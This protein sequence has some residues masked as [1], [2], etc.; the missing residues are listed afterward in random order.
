[1]RILSIFLFILIFASC[2]SEK[3]GSNKENKLKMG[4]GCSMDST[5]FKKT[6]IFASLA[7]DRN[8]TPSAVSLLKYA[9]TRKSQGQQS[10]CVGWSSSYSART[11]LE[12][13][14]TGQNPDELAFAPG[15][16]YNQ[17][18][19]GDCHVGS[20]ISD[21]MDVLKNQGDIFLAD[22]PYS[23]TACDRLP[24]GDEKGK[25]S[26]FK[27]LGYNRITSGMGYEID[28]NALKQNIAQGAP[29]VVALPVGGSFDNLFGQKLWKP[30]SSDN[31]KLDE[32]KAGNYENSGLGGH[33]MT[34][35]G[36]DDDLSGG[37]VQI[38]NSW[39]QEFGEN[40]V[41]WMPYSDFKKWC[42]EAYAIFPFPKETQENKGKDF[43]A[44]IGL[45]ANKTKD[46]I[47]LEKSGD[48]TFTTTKKL[49]P[50]T[51][52]KIEVN[53]SMAC[54]IY[55]LGQE[56]D[57][58][59]YV[60]FPYTEYHSPYC[61]ITGTRVFPSDYSMKLDDIGN[62]DLMVVLLSKQELDITKI[63]DSMNK[64]KNTP[65]ADRLKSLI[66]DGII[67]TN[68]M[69]TQV[70]QT[71]DLDVMDTEGIVVPMFIEILK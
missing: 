59:S 65:Y 66:Q 46:Y 26:N 61:G 12:A 10:S 2:K 57:G 6:K 42:M 24:N 29:V 25:A 1:M 7:G 5:K 69:K 28:L 51:K 40:G 52:F 15:F 20:Y 13:Y 21:A 48:Y 53:N 30:T 8:E 45:L 16:V 9:P 37:S 68:K 62:K 3:G 67:P 63:N 33:A 19:Q 54:Y 23:E 56:T 50:G 43:Q 71:M 55:V 36:Y 14:R 17:I 64:D 44:S 22:F 47:S 38:M 34:V 35:I 49:K 18:R 41:F 27:I 11:I 60:L 58:S 70:G 32:F 4:V 39:G 31:D